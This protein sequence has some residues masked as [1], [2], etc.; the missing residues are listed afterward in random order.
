[1]R[2]FSHFSIAAIACLISIGCAPI[3]QPPRE[4]IT[5]DYAPET[6]APPGSAD[7][8]F[9]IVGTQFIVTSNNPQSMSPQQSMFPQPS[10]QPPLIFLQ[11]ASNM[12][13]DLQ[14]VLTARGYGIRGYFDTLDGM[15]YPDKEGSDLI[16]TA[17]V[18]FRVH[19]NTVRYTQDRSNPLAA[20]C[21][22]SVPIIFL[23]LR[24]YDSYKYEPTGP[25]LAGIGWMGIMF[26]ASFWLIPGDFVPAG[27]VEISSEVI[28]EAYEGL[29]NEVMWSKKIPIPASTIEPKAVLRSKGGWRGAREYREYLEHITWQELMKID[30]KFYSDLVRAFEGQYD[31]VLSQI[32]TYLDP[33]EMAIVKNQAMELRK[34]KVY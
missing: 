14:E 24:D 9:A 11:L 7:V 12:T 25:V 1:M 26:A 4:T 5:F 3:T 21:G 15:I 17:K 10:P 6:E 8:T 33:R 20:G 18:K 22:C 34:R 28:L 16:L 13:Q 27:H 23:L 32:Y 2:Y 29:T 30:N 31:K 19:N